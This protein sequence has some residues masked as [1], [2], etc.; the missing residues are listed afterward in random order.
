MALLTKKQIEQ[1]F[2]IG[3][4]I[5]V[6]RDNLKFVI[7]Q[8]MELI[9]TYK[10]NSPAPITLRNVRF[11]N[12]GTGNGFPFALSRN[13]L[14]FWHL[15]GSSFTGAANGTWRT[16]LQRNIVSIVWT[17][18]RFRTPVRGYKYGADKF[19]NLIEWF[20]SLGIDHNR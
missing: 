1:R 18:N 15:S 2:P 3:S 4:I 13:Y 20:T 5:P 8:G 16:A 14:R 7:Q 12:Y 17:G 10:G 6:N 19:L 11:Y 9:L